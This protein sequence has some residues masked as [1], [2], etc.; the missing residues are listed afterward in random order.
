MAVMDWPARGPGEQT[1]LLL[2]NGYVLRNRK[3][4]MALSLTTSKL[5]PASE[6]D[7]RFSFLFL[8]NEA[9]RSPESTSAAKASGRPDEGRE[10]Q[11]TGAV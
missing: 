7:E 1:L 9:S 11:V 10:G 6:I 3:S 4:E 5:I 8:S 2:V